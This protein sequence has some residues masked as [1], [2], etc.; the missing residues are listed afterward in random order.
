[1]GEIHNHEIAAVTESFKAL[2]LSKDQ[3]VWEHM[4]TLLYDL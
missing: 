3:A 4:I 1:M 2:R